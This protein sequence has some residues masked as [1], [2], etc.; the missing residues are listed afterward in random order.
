MS[1]TQNLGDD[2]LDRLEDELKAAEQKIIDANLDKILERLQKEQLEQNL[3]YDEYN[4]EIERLRRE[5]ENVEQ[6]AAS[7]PDGCFRKPALEV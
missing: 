2:E 3:L 6:I 7:L 5:V 1:L 4:A